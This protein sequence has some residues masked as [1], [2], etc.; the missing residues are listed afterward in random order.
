[1]RFKAVRAPLLVV[2]IA[3]AMFMFSA[4]P[5]LCEGWIFGVRP[6]NMVESAYFGVN[7]GSLVPFVG[8]DYLSAS[9]DIEDVEASASLFVPHFGIRKYFGQNLVGGAVV[10]YLQASFLKSFASIDVGGES[11]ELTDAIADLMSFYGATFAF[12]AEYFFT[13]RFSVGGEY[14]LRY[15]KMSTELEVDLDIV[16]EPVSLDSDLDVTYKAS[17]AIVSLNFH[18]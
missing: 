14:G 2:A 6:G 3:L 4:M 10:P 12:G 17:Y 18:F 13:D 5:A 8:I 11:S 16:D 9:V 1:M 7:M 15:L